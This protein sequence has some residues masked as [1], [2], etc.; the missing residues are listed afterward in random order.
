M[1]QAHVIT[2]HGFFSLMVQEPATSGTKI[3]LQFKSC[4]SVRGD[5]AWRGGHGGYQGLGLSWIADARL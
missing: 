5:H 3:L 1:G 4:V 2:P